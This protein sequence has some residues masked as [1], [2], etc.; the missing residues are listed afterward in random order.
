L[1][2]YW[3]IFVSLIFGVVV[4]LY[5]AFRKTEKKKEIS[6]LENVKEKVKKQETDTKIELAKVKADTGKKIE[7]LEKIKKIG[8]NKNRADALADFLSREFSD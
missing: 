7:Q 3:W 6:I 1:A 4:A 2:K 5:F 8:D